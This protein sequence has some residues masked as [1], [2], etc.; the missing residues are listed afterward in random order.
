[1]TTL[2]LEDWASYIKEP[3]A[4]EQVIKAEEAEAL[5]AAIGQLSDEQQ[6]VIILR[7][8]EGMSHAG[9]ADIL[10]KSAGACRVIQ[11]RALATLSQ[12]LTDQLSADNRPLE[13]QRA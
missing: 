10:G 6:Q 3:A 1:M 11:H 13:V 7:F 2:P 5:S 9:V 8:I 12:L 4:L